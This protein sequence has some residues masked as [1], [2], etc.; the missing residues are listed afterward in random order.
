MKFIHIADVHWGMNPDNDKPWSRER[1]QAIK[2][3]L[4]EV[5]RQAKI[6]DVDLLLV[7]GDLF[8]RQP[9]LRDLKEVNYLFSTIPGV[10]VVIV[11]G[12]HDRI[13]SSSALFSF[14][15]SSNV[16]WLM[17]EDF[18]SVVFEDLN[19]EI[20]G[21]SY[22]TTEITEARLYDFYAPATPR[23]HILLV[24]GGDT[25]HLPL[26]K[27]Q[28]SDNGFTYN[29][30]GHIHK[31]ELSDNRCWAYPGSPEPLDKTE[32]GLHGMVVGEISPTSH[33]VTALEFIPLAQIQYIPLA[34]N[35]TPATTNG[36]LTDRINQE[37]QKRGGE[38]IF[39]FRIRGMRDPDITFDLKLLESRLRIAE[40]IDESEPQYD[41]SQLFADHPSD[42][43]G[44]YIRELQKDVMSP[45]EK[46]ALFYGIDALL[47]T[48][49]ERS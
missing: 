43:I 45:V 25:A 4:G 20:T 49:D 36:E 44:F 23:I 42:M 10:K 18:S 35:V 16:T 17:E 32:T 21:F 9:L 7:A 14:T 3:T 29:A 15:W 1:A 13:R 48:Q 12:N 6:R 8:H 11:A 5:I 34:V 39:R 30:L 40:I 33:Q 19:T 31:A 38:N 46:K 24:H 41:F 47:R 22:H 27:K 37:I 2:D 26:D 28:L